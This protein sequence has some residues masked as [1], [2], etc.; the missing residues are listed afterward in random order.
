M[1]VIVVKTI[2]KMI[3]VIVMSERTITG[4]GAIDDVGQD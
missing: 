2:M 3:M 1:M 4:D